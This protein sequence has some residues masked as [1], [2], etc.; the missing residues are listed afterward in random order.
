[1]AA[2]RLMSFLAL[3]LTI[4]LAPA[5]ARA[6]EPFISFESIDAVESGARIVITGI[7]TGE[8]TPR[9]VA[10][11]QIYDERCEASCEKL[12]LLALSK[13]GVYRFEAFHESF[14]FGTCKLVRRTP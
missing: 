7:V 1:M 2:M 5:P 8:S 10:L 14:G 13:P 3:V 9:T 11:V 12:A 6:A 4:S